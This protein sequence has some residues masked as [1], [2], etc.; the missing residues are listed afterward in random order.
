MR[1]PFLALAC[2]L[3]LLAAAVGHGSARAA[4]VMTA[5]DLIANVNALR[6]SH[7]LAPYKTNSQ[8]MSAAQ[9]HS[10]YQASSG[11]AS[12][13]GKG[14]STPT[15]RARA[16]GYGGGKSVSVSENI[17]WGTSMSAPRAVEIWQLDAPHLLTMLGRYTHVGAGVASANGVT[18]FTL[19]AG[20]VSGSP[21]EGL[22]D[23]QPVPVDDSAADSAPDPDQ[24]PPASLGPAPVVVATPDEHGAVVHIVRSGQAL[25]TIAV[26]YEVALEELYD[27]NG[28]HEN[29]IIY[30]GDEIIIDPGD[31]LE[32]D[33]VAEPASATPE[34]T[35]TRRPTQTDAPPPTRTPRP[36]AAISAPQAA[37]A[38]QQENPPPGSGLPDAG[39]VNL[40]SFR[41]LAQLTLVVLVFL[42]GGLVLL[43][44]L[45]ERR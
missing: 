27:L 18:Y 9:K 29:S 20:F 1:R 30:A 15:G 38:A 5:A 40:S 19:V 11:Q 10:E 41:S 22:N 37:A 4:P 33:A 13:S 2:S 34:A 31:L 3:F 8:L 17:A 16:A 36:A 7:G 28:L 32:A 39:P 35:A 12:H 23:P 42:A 44:N 6:A 45:Q 25:Y 26:V 24:A 43:G 14:G 21:G